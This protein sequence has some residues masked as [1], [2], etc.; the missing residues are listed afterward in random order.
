MITKVLK[1]H[2]LFVLGGFVLVS[3]DFFDHFV[4]CSY[5]LRF[6]VGNSWEED[7]IIKQIS[8]NQL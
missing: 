7:I 3:L 1:D 2:E 4:V 5:R 8:S 6:K